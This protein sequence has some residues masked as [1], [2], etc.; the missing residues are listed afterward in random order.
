MGRLIYLDSNIYLDYFE[1]RRDIL[2]PLGEFAFRLLKRTMNCEFEILVSS[3][4]IDEVEK[5]GYLTDLNYLFAE[6]ELLNKLYRVQVSQSD[7]KRVKQLAS[8]RQSHTEDILHAVLAEKGGADFLVT[9][10]TKDF[11]ELQDLVDIVLPEA[12]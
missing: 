3:H 7:C 4:I 10:N 2:R 12:L 9:R 6:L 5:Q 8:E 11:Q 1:N